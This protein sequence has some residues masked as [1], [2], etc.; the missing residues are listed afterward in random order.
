MVKSQGKKTLKNSLLG[1]IFFL[2]TSLLQGCYLIDQ[3]KGQLSLRWNQIP[4]AEAIQTETNPQYRELLSLVP[5]VK[6]FA[7]S[8][9]YSSV[10]PSAVAPRIQTPQPWT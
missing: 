5:K 7:E 10:Y 6:L 4:I 8:L 2:L 1:T 3:T 9:P